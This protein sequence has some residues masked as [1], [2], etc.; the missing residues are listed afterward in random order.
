MKGLQPGSYFS[1]DSLE[2]RCS[3][4]VAEI[5]NALI[6]SVILLLIIGV[7]KKA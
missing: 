3:C 5:I 1:G 2:I 6:G 7:F 4:I